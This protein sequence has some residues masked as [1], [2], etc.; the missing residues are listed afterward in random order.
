MQKRALRILRYR[1]K[2]RKRIMENF[3]HQGVL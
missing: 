3:M 1:I 2:E